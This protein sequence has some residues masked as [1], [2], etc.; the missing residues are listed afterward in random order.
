MRITSDLI[1]MTRGEGQLCVEMLE[2][3]V[4]ESEEGRKQ[5]RECACVQLMFKGKSAIG[6]CDSH[7]YVES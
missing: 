5:S 1:E 7:W 6:V 3:R 2:S 4:L